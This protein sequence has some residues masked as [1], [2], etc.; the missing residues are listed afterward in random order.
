MTRAATPLRRERAATKQSEITGA[1]A[2]ASWLAWGGLV[3]LALIWCVDFHFDVR[4]QDAQTWMDPYQYLGF[5]EGLAA[6]ELAPRDLSL[7]SIFPFF[8]APA[9]A[10]SP[11]I[12]AALWVNAVFMALLLLSI[13][14]LCVELRMETPSFVPALLVLTSPLLIGLSRSL[15]VEFA[16]TSLVA[17]ACWA[18]LRLVRGAGTREAGVHVEG[19]RGQGARTADA[20]G[21][22]LFGVLFAAG[23]MMKMTFPLFVALPAAGAALGLI[24]GGRLKRALHLASAVALPAVIVLGIQ[25][26]FFPGTLEYYRTLGNTTMPIM[27]LIG[28]EER[29]SLDS[30]TYY[31]VQL[32][33]SLLGLLAPFLLLPL[34]AGVRGWRPFR[35]ESLTGATASLWMWFVGPLLLLTLQTVKEPRHFAPCVV[36]AVLLIVLGIESLPRAGVRRALIAAVLLAGCVQHAGVTRLGWETPYFLDRPLHLDRIVAAMETAVRDDAVDDGTPPALRGLHWKFNRNV[37]I[38]GFEPNAALALTWRLFPAVTFDLDTLAPA[39]GNAGAERAEPARGAAGRERHGSFEDLFVLAAFNTYNRRCGWPV[40]HA[41][42]QRGEVLRQAD[43][44]LAGGEHSPAALAA[45]FPDHRWIASLDLGEDPLHILASSHGE[46][47]PYRALHAERF[48][49]AHP[50]LDEAERGVIARELLYVH[51]LRGDLRGAEA[52]LARFPALREGGGARR[53][54]YW[55]GAYTQLHELARQRYVRSHHLISSGEQPP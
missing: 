53:N 42:L 26:L 47:T 32:W 22:V 30:L 51:V 29:L 46:V 28:P 27:Y 4:G 44:L 49:A 18:W 5:A 14:L 12:P 19:G 35:P 41:T 25:A 17:L 43:F 13:H 37:V 9:L 31:P 39:E 33:R 21:V 55:I 16:L 54:I 20:R 2:A 24:L 48:L 6:G 8:I 45:R 38:T 40:Y 1:T 52:L 34:V 11:T 23:F 15:Y 10:L 50:N 7:P 36:P 3:L